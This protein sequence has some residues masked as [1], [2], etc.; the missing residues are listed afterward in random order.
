[1]TN[2]TH[3]RGGGL[4]ALLLILVVA[5][6]AIA[7]TFTVTTTADTG[8]GSF[9]QAIHDA[10]ASPG[11]DL[12]AFSIGN[13]HQTITPNSA[14]PV[15]HDSGTIDGRTQ[16]GWSGSPLVEIDGSLLLVWGDCLT[17]SEG[18]TVWSLVV[19]RCRSSGIGIVGE[20][21]PNNVFGCY[22]GTD[23]TGT[24]KRANGTGIR[25]TAGSIGGTEP[26]Q[27]NLVSGNAYGIV[28]FND[29]TIT[30][31]LIGTTAGGSA[32]LGNDGIGVQLHGACTLGGNTRAAGNVIVGS[33]IGVSMQ[34]AT[35]SRVINNSIGM[36]GN[37]AM[38]NPGN[39]ILIEGTGHALIQDNRI[40]GSEVAIF[41]NGSS[42]GNLFLS[43]SIHGNGFGIDLSSG[44][45]GRVTLNDAEDADIGPNNLQNFPVLTGAKVQDRTL[46]IA[47]SLQSK[48]SSTFRVQ[49]FGS[50]A[51]NASG[52]GEGLANI[53]YVD[54]TTDASG[55]VTF[56]ETFGVTLPSG[57]VVTATASSG[58]EGTSELSRC[59][60]VEGAGI[61]GF[62][63][64]SGNVNEGGTVSR[65]VTRT[66]GTVG[67]ASVNWAAAAGTALAGSDFPAGGGTLSFAD[68]E[69]EKT[70]QI[71]LPDDAV[72]EG[73]ETF[74]IT[75]S[76]STAGSAV[77][78]ARKTSSV[79]I[80]D[81]DPR[82]AVTF[83]RP[84]VLEGDS[85]TRPA[86][87]T[88]HLA[89]P[90][91]IPV[92]IS[93]Y[94][95]GGSAYYSDFEYK[96]G[97]LT[98]QPGETMKSVE[99]L[100]VG[101][102]VAEADEYFFLDGYSNQATVNY[103][104]ATI[105]NDDAAPV[106]SV[107]DVAVTETDANQ[108]V[109]VTLTS[110]TPAYGYAY[111]TTRAATA[112]SGTDYLASSRYVYWEGQTQRTF[113]FTVRGD[114]EVEADEW[115][116]IGIDFS[117]LAVARREG[118][119]TILNDDVGV[120]PA[121]QRI[122]L[123]TSA[124][125]VINLGAPFATDAEITL[126]S[127]A[128]DV[129][130]VP[131]SIGV[132]TGDTRA[133]FD[134]RALSADGSAR[135]DIILP[136]SMGGETHIVTATTYVARR[137]V[138]S[139]TELAVYVGQTLPVTASLQPPSNQPLTITLNTTTD[140]A[141]MPS[142]LVIPAGG[143]TTF[144]VT[145]LQPGPIAVQASLGTQDL[146]GIYGHVT[147]T[148][149]TAAILRIAPPIGPT[150]GGTLVDVTG[151]HFRNGCTLSF[152]G[153]DATGIQVVSSTQLRAT[154]PPH[155]AATVNVFLACD[156]DV[157]LFTNGF[158]YVDATPEIATVVP[159]FGNVAGGTEVRISGANFRSSCWPSFGGIAAMRA[160]VENATSIAATVPPH[161]AGAVEVS[162][163][164]TGS[165]AVR[166]AAFNY[167]TS[168]EPLA[169]IQSVD[170]LAGSP[171]QPVTVT[172]LRFRTTDRVTFGPTPATILSTRS[173]EHVVRIPELAFGK[174][175]VTLTGADGHVTTTGPIF[176]VLE[177]VPPIVT[178]IVPAALP[179]G[180][181]LRLDGRGFRPGYL[182][183][184]GGRL[185]TIASLEYTSVVV[186]LDPAVMPG[187]HNVEIY[188][189][190][191]HM[192]GIGP[193]VHV[194]A[195]GVA[196][197]GIDVACSTT[198]GGGTVTIIGT[199]FASGA[200]VRFDGV[201][202]TGVTVDDATTIHA[203]VPAGEAGAGVITVTNPDG[204]TA[205]LTGRFRYVSPFDPS[206]GCS[207]G[208]RSRGV[209]H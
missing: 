207:N 62:Q 71:V 168:P 175:S 1:M 26:G 127:S 203:A 147:D 102:Q 12:V 139:H 151:V 13:G 180:A 95:S 173:G 181:E 196:I 21:A 33:S 70:I 84:S 15:F 187:D 129:V 56:D 110:T 66:A 122:A 113:T 202:S 65:T 6:P 38:P 23:V 81:N 176:T 136:P 37:I 78:T 186:R 73:N 25:A 20:S 32:V 116:T 161:A 41:A 174:T 135:I 52:H 30:G 19:N 145:G 88:L 119:V 114:D 184:V 54:V 154:T 7:A 11:P 190:A 125:F 90:S 2:D 166:A 40:S 44:G 140:A 87:F 94:T 104:V 101:D 170:P 115:L 42:L 128:P 123:G 143:S 3:V 14:L 172:G 144:D 58:T 96:S 191:G 31:N 155:D 150:A 146:G 92:V 82:P 162:L 108:Q 204:S 152:D 46:R 199:G 68:G 197:H 39:G 77:D 51:C 188:N 89:P 121:E 120:G 103:G 178:A 160:M 45:S 206:G 98:F 64:L 50:P 93:Y 67:A 148:P 153:L 131:N 24:Q 99:V 209:R 17:I 106:I 183:R 53:G 72:Y 47:G 69:S 133:A 177:A 194:M 132:R 205:R 29:V 57:Y 97:S 169:T 75:L 79:T 130:A 43:N 200:I 117:S 118:R 201:A 16:P 76:S 134:A 142:T 86:T 49:F 9:R 109:T 179:A 27:A 55:E 111:V 100:V 10:N 18:G 195:T 61:F 164:C 35:R 105:R 34:N 22:I 138:F 48:K 83:S 80:V 171:G 85:G 192:A 156:G 182:F 157:W 193:R 107:E 167:T 189:A 59:V 198:E 5:F 163:Q 36:S 159:D 149:V 165:D 91:A 74:A 126:V 60:S 185:A 112:K 141:S 28:A 63:S 8:A 158:T 4:A 137:L 208:G 124:P